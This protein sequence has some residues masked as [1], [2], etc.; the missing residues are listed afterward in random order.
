MMYFLINVI[1]QYIAERLQSK[2]LVLFANQERNVVVATAKRNHSHGN[3]SHRIERFGFET[4]VF[5]FQIAHHADDAHVLV[6]SNRTVFLQVIENLVQVLD[7]YLY[8]VLKHR[9]K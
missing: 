4:N 5:P 6:D 8:L 2:F 1:E 9:M 3:V 7:V